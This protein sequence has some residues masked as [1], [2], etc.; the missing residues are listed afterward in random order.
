MHASLADVHNEQ[1]TDINVFLPNDTTSCSIAQ[2]PGGLLS[3]SSVSVCETHSVPLDRTMAQYV[4]SCDA[5]MTTRK[6]I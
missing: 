2:P 5:D 6:Q 4:S 3:R 1:V